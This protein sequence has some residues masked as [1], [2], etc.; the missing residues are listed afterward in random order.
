[1]IVQ[2]PGHLE[3]LGHRRE[4]GLQGRDI[5]TPRRD[6]KGNPGKKLTRFAIIELL[7]FADITPALEQKAG[8]RGD[9]A[10]TVDAGEG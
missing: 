10:G 2:L 5:R 3:G 1:M 8:D 7:G 6:I 4:T 9:D